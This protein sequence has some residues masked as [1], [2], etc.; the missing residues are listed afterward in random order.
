MLVRWRYAIPCKTMRCTLMASTNGQE[1][2]RILAH[3]A[4]GAR[5]SRSCCSQ[6]CTAQCSPIAAAGSARRSVKTLPGNKSI[7]VALNLQDLGHRLFHSCGGPAQRLTERALN[8]WVAPLLLHCAAEIE[9]QSS[10]RSATRIR[11]SAAR[12]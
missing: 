6:D 5:P 8:E 11:P 4:Q 10:R 12:H 2:E 1:Q 3:L 7:S 9:R